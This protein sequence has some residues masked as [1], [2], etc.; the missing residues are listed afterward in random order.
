MLAGRLVYHDQKSILV[1]KSYVV[2][3]GWM[4]G[5]VQRG[6]WDRG[7]QAKRPNQIVGLWVEWY[8]GVVRRELR[9][10]TLDK[11]TSKYIL[12]HQLILCTNALLK[13]I[14]L[15]FVVKHGH[16]VVMKLV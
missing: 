13:C 4:E 7:I 2:G 15:P 6:L 12:Y 14:F 11:K 9:G 3:Q 5:M 8:R 16:L 10:R 1:G